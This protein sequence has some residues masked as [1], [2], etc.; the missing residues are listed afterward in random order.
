MNIDH[1]ISDDCSATTPAPVV[2]VIDAE[3][4][5]L[6][7]GSEIPGEIKGDISRGADATARIRNSLEQMAG[8]TGLRLTGVFNLELSKDTKKAAKKTAKKTAKKAAKKSAPKAAAKPAAARDGS[9][10]NGA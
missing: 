7:S 8:G 9:S 4:R 5:V 10:R 2:I 6:L 1:G 3:I